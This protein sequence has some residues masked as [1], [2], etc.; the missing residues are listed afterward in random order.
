MKTKSFFMALVLF[1]LLGTGTVNAV[2]QA[3]APEAASNAT[4][5][6]SEVEIALGKVAGAGKSGAPAEKRFKAL[7][8]RATSTNAA[9]R[10]SRFTCDN[11][12]K[13]VIC[14][15]GKSVCWWGPKNGYGCSF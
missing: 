15:D 10:K 4:E 3:K 12:G 2:E 13:V 1:V 9:L 8:A 14:T 6:L 11:I 5:P 7:S